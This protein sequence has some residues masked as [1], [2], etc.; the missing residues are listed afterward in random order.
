MELLVINREKI[1]LVNNVLLF[2]YFFLLLG[3]DNFDVH[4]K[5]LILN[6]L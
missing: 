4:E 3:I 5:I 1:V 6:L 2:L